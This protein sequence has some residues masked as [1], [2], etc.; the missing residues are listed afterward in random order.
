MIAL[1][2]GRLWSRDFVEAVRPPPHP[3]HIFAQQVM[4]LTLQE[5]GVTRGD[6]LWIGEVLTDADRATAG[7]V[8]DYMLSTGV[9]VEDNGVLGLGSEAEAK[10]GR[11]HFQELVAA[12][13]TPLLL[14]VRY[15]SHELGSIDPQSLSARRDS[16]PVILLGGRSWRVLNIDWP[17]RTVAVEPAA[18]VGSSRWFGSSRSLH[19]EAAQS[20]EQILAGGD[21]GVSLSTRAGVILQGLREDMPYIDGETLPVVTT[22]DEMRIWTFAGGRAN[23]MLAGAL[24]AAGGFLRTLDN[25]GITLRDMDKA[26]L[27][28]LLDRITDADCRVLV[29]ARMMTD[30]K[31]GVCLPDYLAEDVI[32]IRMSNF[33][34]L[35]RCLQ[36]SRKWVRIA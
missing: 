31:F 21:A 1:G 34:A 19:A 12:F 18:E 28:S 9:L 13:T 22:G 27:A 10:F 15:G 8:I 29:D 5:G 24:R 35:H 14:A 3:A 33:D 2:I 32:R 6:C 36:R 17:R 26:T 23:A 30:L 7:A 11:R 20:V 16:V 25:F 4:G